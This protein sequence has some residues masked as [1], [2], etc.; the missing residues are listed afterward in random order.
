MPRNF[1][2]LIIGDEIVRGK[3][4]DRHFQHLVETLAARGLHLSWSLYVADDRPR[5]IHI[6]QRTLQ[7][8]DIVFSFGGIGATPDDHTRQ[9]VAAAAGVALQLH[10]DAAAE[11]HAYCAQQKTAVTPQRLRLGELPAGSRIVPN[12][13]NRMPGFSLG[14]HHFY[15][16]F[17]QMAW[18]MLAWTLDTY[19]R[20]EF[21]AVA[22]SEQSIFIA[23]G[24]EGP[25]LPLMQQMEI[26]YQQAH[27]FSLP[28]LGDS[29]CGRVLELG[30]RGEPSQVVAAMLEI[31][32]EVTRLGFDW[33]EAPAKTPE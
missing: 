17:A 8:S 31:R 2:A 10:P 18:P 24:M 12:P 4:P 6:L 13:V 15:P 7:S 11:I 22:E 3:R 1:G 29:T 16:G 32:S 14:D 30:M 21:H 28:S 27:L 23:N 25:L 26:K 9:A 5:L 20:S 19:Y 33:L